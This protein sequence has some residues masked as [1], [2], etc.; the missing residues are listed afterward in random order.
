[1][2]D[3][4]SGRSA[5]TPSSRDWRSSTPFARLS[6]TERA[7]ALRS[8]GMHGWAPECRV[9]S[10]AYEMRDDVTVSDACETAAQLLRALVASL[11]GLSM[12]LDASALHRDALSGCVFI[13]RQAA[14]A[15]AVVQAGALPGDAASDVTPDGPP[16]ASDRVVCSR[17]HLD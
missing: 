9:G 2:S 12:S 13:A 7:E 8:S 5:P 4:D 1:M 16:R 14:G 15:L 10:D 6:P 17:E 3:A 11:E